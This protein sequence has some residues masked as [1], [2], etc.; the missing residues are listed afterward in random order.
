VNPENTVFSIKRLIGRK[1]EDASVQYDI[2]RLPYK[3]VAAPNGD[4]RV[5]MGG[6]DH[7]PQEISAM[8]LQKLKADAEAYLG[9]KVTDAVITVPAYFND[10]QRQGPGC[11]ASPFERLRISTNPPIVPRLRHG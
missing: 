4:C 6:K 2:K 5:V 7:S 1:Y 3:I 10:S 8:I 11:R 9:E